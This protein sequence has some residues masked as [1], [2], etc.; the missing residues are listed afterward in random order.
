MAN[1]SNYSGVMPAL[2]AGSRFG[3]REDE[4]ILAAYM[5]LLE[6]SDM[7]RQPGEIATH[8]DPMDIVERFRNESYQPRATGVPYIF[9]GGSPFPQSPGQMQG[10]KIAATGALTT[11]VLD[12]IAGVL[13]AILDAWNKGKKK[14]QGGQ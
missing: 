5:A 4:D 8:Q 9:T 1:R 10:E 12:S 7:E 3:S 11:N 2:L 14:K 6:G 13:P